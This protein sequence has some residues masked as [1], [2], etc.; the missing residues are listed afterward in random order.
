[1]I[2]PYRAAGLK[3]NPFVAEGSPGVA[4]EHWTDRRLPAS[5]TLRPGVFVQVIGPKGSGKTSHLLRWR[6]SAPGP[7]RHVRPGWGRLRPLPAGPVVYW[8]E[9]DRALWIK[10]AL[11]IQGRQAA[12]V[13]V[14]THRNLSPMARKAGFRVE[15]HELGRLTPKEVEAFAAR[16]IGAAGGEPGQFA[17]IDYDDIARRA[18][19]SLREAG[20]LL[21]IEVA[22]RVRAEL[23][24]SE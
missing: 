4:E 14:G 19:A 24:S 18:G 10:A 5:L 22:R 6:A 1:M 20:R 12:M 16:R 3:R 11:A 8:D 15:T 23:I 17:D 13:V 9:A 2:D 21:H 7:Y